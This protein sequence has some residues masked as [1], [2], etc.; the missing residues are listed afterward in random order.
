MKEKEHSADVSRCES[1]TS[2]VGTTTNT[3]SPTPLSDS[4]PYLGQ[5]VPTFSANVQN[6]R[7][8]DNLAQP[9]LN[10]GTCLGLV[11]TPG[12]N[13]LAG[14][15]D[16]QVQIQQMQQLQK[17]QQLLAMQPSLQ[18]GVASRNNLAP[19]QD[20]QPLGFQTMMNLLGNSSQMNFGGFQPVNA[21]FPP[22]MNSQPALNPILF[23]AR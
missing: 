20:T 9:A 17:L 19:A 18:S 21:C 22:A 7:T 4:L 10:Q 12:L 1:T 11:T 14:Q 13:L 6:L 5:H 15:N 23:P 16:I 8:Q 2:T 3:P